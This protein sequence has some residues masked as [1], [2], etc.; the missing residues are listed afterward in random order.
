M[1]EGL[2]T[3]ARLI[4]GGC[5]LVLACAGCVLPE[6]AQREILEGNRYSDP[7]QISSDDFPAVEEKGRLAPAKGSAARPQPTA[8]AQLDFPD[9]T[10]SMIA[11]AEEADQKSCDLPQNCDA[12]EVSQSGLW[13]DFSCAVGVL[14]R[15]LWARIEAW[16]Y[17]HPRF[18]PVPLQPA[19]TPGAA[20]PPGASLDATSEANESFVPRSEGSPQSEI[21]LPA[22]LPRES[23][24]PSEPE[25]PNRVARLERPLERASRR[26]SWIFSPPMPHEPVPLINSTRGRRPPDE[27]SDGR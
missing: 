10:A 18:H 22:P 19:F 8:P 25:R 21:L 15:P 9:P 13:C 20:P 12:P 7:A 1:R 16:R 6:L 17:R 27:L 14:R 11:S 4:C 24:T 3:S 26:G 23:P 5:C 2:S